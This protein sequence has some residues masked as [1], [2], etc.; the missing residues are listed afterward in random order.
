M[1]IAGR[2]NKTHQSPRG[3]KRGSEKV[4]KWEREKGEKGRG[5]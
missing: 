2:H 1:F 5:I 3:G 4:G